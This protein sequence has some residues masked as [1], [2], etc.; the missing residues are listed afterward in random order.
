MIWDYDFLYCVR[1]QT[2]ENQFVITSNDY[3]GFRLSKKANIQ[4]IDDAFTL[5]SVPPADINRWHGVSYN[6]ANLRFYSDTHNFS[7]ENV[8]N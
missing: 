6:A 2:D 5:C 4:S 8:G 3:L 1:S 7:G